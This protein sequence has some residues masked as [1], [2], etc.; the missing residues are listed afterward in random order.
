MSSGAGSQAEAQ[1][2][3][4]ALAVYG[5]NGV[6]QECLQLQERYGADV[7]VLLCALWMARRGSPLDRDTMARLIEVAGPWH[8]AVV[9]PLRAV[10]QRMKDGPPPAPNTRTDALRD[11]V[12]AAELTAERIELATLAEFIAAEFP[13]GPALEPAAHLSV[14]LSHYADAPIDDDTQTDRLL[15]AARAAALG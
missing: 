9:K 7:P 12:K 11:A 4:F 13:I 10:R 3:R 6:S 14:A 2:W 1:L 5:T 15:D 8:M